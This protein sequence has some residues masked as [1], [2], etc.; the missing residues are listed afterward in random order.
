[1]LR[2]LFGLFLVAHGLVHLGFVS[3]SP[4]PAPGAPEWPFEMGRSWLIG[5]VGHAGL[6]RGIGA[7]L[8]ITTLVAF[9]GAGLA[10]FG[11]L[12]PQ[13]WWPA[14]TIAGSATSLAVLVVFFHP[15]LVIGLAI[16]AALIVL[17]VGSGWR[18]ETSGSVSEQEETM[19]AVVVYESLWGNTAAIARAIA[20]GLGAGAVALT[21]D[22]A[23]P[24][25]IADA[26][27]LIVG[28]PVLGFR[29]GTDSVRESIARS[30]ADAP[31][32]PDLSHP[33]LRSW[34]DALPRGSAPCAA[35]ET[36]IWWSPRGATGD[37]EQRLARAG[38]RVVSHA[39]KFVVKDTYGPLRDGELER[40]RSWGVELARTAP[41]AAS[42]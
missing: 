14:L 27:L 29:L 7:A 30:E 15:W 38:H 11:I 36:R 23:R 22:A 24:E 2:V 40:A 35:F 31:T 8:V 18:A 42:V 3:R 28:A 5:A 33:S 26:D 12:V 34:L 39:R 16:D 37:I 6:V 41:V 17:V 20:D 25:S 4:A 21:T 1:M 13:A 10:W 19:K 32:P 9:V